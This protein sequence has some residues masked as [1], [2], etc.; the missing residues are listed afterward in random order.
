[1]AINWFPGHMHKATKEIKQLLP[2]V[3]AIIEV[4]DARIP[5]SS[6]NPVIAKFRRDIP[7]IKLLNKT[8]LA[9]PEAT[10]AWRRHFDSDENTTSLPISAMNRDQVLKILDLIHDRFHVKIDALKPV[11]VMI[12]GIPNVGKSTIINV[13]A[14]RTIAKTGNEP[15]VTKGQQKIHLPDNVYLW[16]TPGILWGKLVNQ[17]GAYR[18]AATGAI[19]ETAISNDEI[20]AWTAE[21]LLARYPDRLVARY[22]LAETPRDDIDFLEQ[23]GRKRG[24]LAS[25][26]Q[27]DFEKTAKILLTELRDGKLGRITLELPDDMIAEEAEVQAKLEAELAAKE[28]KKTQRKRKR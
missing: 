4:L 1:M 25:G 5:Y 23:M 6:S 8:D 9:D 11:N 12:T 16:D 19:K 7:T 14:G 28:E 17:N 27:I 24:C 20:G 10:E 21:A 18:L 22:G 13:I 3:D 26:G 2:N 15:A